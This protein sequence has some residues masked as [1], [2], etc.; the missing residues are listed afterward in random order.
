[1][2]KKIVFLIIFFVIA[3][4]SLYL[5]KGAE[6]SKQNA[7]KRRETADTIIPVRTVPVTIDTVETIIEI[8]GSL[9]SDFETTVSS[10]VDGVIE[11]TSRE[12]GDTINKNEMLVKIK[13]VEYEI[14]KR[15]AYYDYMQTLVKL[16][17]DTAPIDLTS[18]NLENISSVKKARANY[19]NV[20]SNLWRISEL[21]KN[22][23]TSKQL[24]D[25]TESKLKAAEADLQFA[26]EEAKN[27][28]LTVQNKKAALDL[29][30]KKYN[31]T[32]ILAPYDGYIQKRIVSPGEYIKAGTPVY[33][34]IKMDPIKFVGGIP[35]N[36]MPDISLG[37]TV[38]VRVDAV[39]GTYT[40]K[41]TKISPSSTPETHSVNVEVAVENPKFILRPGYFANAKI[42]L[43]VN[44]KG[45]II[46]TEGL[47]IFAGVEKVFTIKD[48]KAFENKI[49]IG[50]RYV[51]R[52]EV[53]SG[54][55]ENSVIAVTNITKLFDGV[56]VK[57]QDQKK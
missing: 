10:E 17:I 37:K 1:M 27:L 24:L 6:K 50:R 35:E 30:E 13:D 49:K 40:G 9:F 14:K 36:Y 4:S 38:E 32:K 29:A 54:L 25:D 48:G 22:D 47:Y 51:D 57:V 5:L 3:A 41:I 53:K 33:S 56:A 16:S 23:L 2:F 44:P 18:V 31:D 15:Q 43:N 26:R 12:M 19:E 20:K 55:S 46:P 34:M 39:G 11:V 45:I 52:I 7:S 42:V 28:I 21:R 8:N